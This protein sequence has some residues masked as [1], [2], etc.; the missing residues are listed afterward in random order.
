M[1][2]TKYFENQS[3]KFERGVA[4]YQTENPLEK[5]IEHWETDYWKNS[6]FKEKLFIGVGHKWGNK[7]GKNEV[8]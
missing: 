4:H 8:G 3:D 5:C 1:K 6:H 7:E 2:F